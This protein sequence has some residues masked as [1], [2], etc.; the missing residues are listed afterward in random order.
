MEVCGGVG[1]CEREGGEGITS[2]ICISNEHVQVVDAR[3]QQ[4]CVFVCACMRRL[5]C[6]RVCMHAV[7][8]LCVCVCV[9]VCGARVTVVGE[10]VRLADG[11]ALALQRTPLDALVPVWVRVRVRLG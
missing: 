3:T 10:V 7:S 1:V 2:S 9:C 6:A 4:T 11:Q 5:Y 8:V